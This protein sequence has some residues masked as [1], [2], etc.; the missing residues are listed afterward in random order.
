MAAMDMGCCATAGTASPEVTPTC[1]ASD[2]LDVP[3][4]AQERRF[5]SRTRCAALGDTPTPR[6]QCAF[7]PHAL[8]EVGHQ[9]C[10]IGL[11]RCGYTLRCS[12]LWRLGG[13]GGWA[14]HSRSGE[15]AQAVGSLGTSPLTRYATGE[16]R[17]D[18]E[19]R[20]TRRV[21]QL[22]SNSEQR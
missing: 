20:K 10:R 21:D 6:A 2:I 7:V 1:S 18:K 13:A 16:A 11:A 4:A 14:G 5:P 9:V 12:F 19:G 3:L 17:G 8:A 22:R 15:A